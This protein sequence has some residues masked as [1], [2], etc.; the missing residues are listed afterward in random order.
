MMVEVSYPHAG[1]N[2]GAVTEAEYARTLG[3]GTPSGIFG[4]PSDPSP[5]FVTTGGLYLRVGTALR[6]CGMGYEVRDQDL[7][8]PIASN[9]AGSAVRQDHVVAR[10]DWVTMTVRA[11][12]RSSAIGG[13]LP[14]LVQQRGVGAYEVSLGSLA[15]P[16]GGTAVNGTLARRAWYIGPD[17]RIRCTSGARPP[18]DPGET[19]YETDTGRYIV[20]TGAEWLTAAAPDDYSLSSVALNSGYTASHNALERASGDVKMQLSVARTAADIPKLTST[21]I[22]KVPA[23]YRPRRVVQATAGSSYGPDC[24]VSVQTDGTVSINPGPDIVPKNR[25]IVFGMMTWFA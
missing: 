13:A 12:V 19:A 5:L 22:G 1:Y 8:I 2:T 7:L 21:A 25:T 17:G 20:S 18:H 4:G 15:V 9:A 16:A 23:G 24:V 14:T 6:I 10:L 3:W 11:A